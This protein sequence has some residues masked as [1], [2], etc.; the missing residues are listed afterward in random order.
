MSDYRFNDEIVSKSDHQFEALLSDFYEKKLRPLCLCRPSGVAMYIA[1][2]YG[3]H[4]IKRLPDGGYDHSPTCDSFEP[5]A[6][7]SGLGELLGGAITENPDDGITNLKLDFSLTK[8][9]GRAAPVPSDVPPTSVTT[10][11]SKLSL[12][13]TLHYLWEQAAFNRWSPA[14]ASKRNWFVVRKHLL[15]VASNNQTK[16]ASLE[17]SLFIP[18]NFVLEQKSDIEQRRKAQLHD[19]MPA[20]GKT[21]KL[22]LLVGELKSMSESRY[23]FKLSFKHL[24]DFPFMMDEDLHKRFTKHFNIEFELWDGR[25]DSH[26]IV[27]CSFYLNA[28]G[29]ANIVEIAAM[30][31]SP[32]W[33]PLENI[34]DYE[35]ISRL[36]TSQRRF[37]KTLRYNLPSTKP[38]ASAVL[39]DT[40]TPCALYI[41]SANMPEST[42]DSMNTLINDS[43]LTSWVWHAP[44]EVMPELP[45]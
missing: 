1:K 21:K 23:G 39:T 36:V 18:E 45:A 38:I 17:Q 28:S 22:K 16:G 11:G 33:I 27:I 14:M 4:I 13:A 8:I 35:L 7:L 12:R 40:T 43:K 42:L 32:Q 41:R 25:D 44:T 9:S 5:P 20:A 34:F 24:P 26:L 31:V 15:K 30:I 19:V 3:K 2:A 29:F 10:K 37:V 6:E